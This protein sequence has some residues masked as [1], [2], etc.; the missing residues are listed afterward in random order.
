LLC[1]G[2]DISKVLLVPSY[3]VK[4]TAHMITRVSNFDELQRPQM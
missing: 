4:S 3:S 2:E 1:L